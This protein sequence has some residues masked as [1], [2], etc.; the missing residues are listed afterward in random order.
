[1]TKHVNF[2]GEDCCKDC[3]ESREEAIKE[4]KV[5]PV[6]KK[7]FG[8]FLQTCREHGEISLET[9]MTTL[10]TRRQLENALKY[11]GYFCGCTLRYYPE[12]D[13]WRTEERRF[14]S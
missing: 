14:G 8:S 5:I 11:Q 10:Q 1:M 9:G 3:F 6:T 4:G 2:D 12:G 13:G 7:Q